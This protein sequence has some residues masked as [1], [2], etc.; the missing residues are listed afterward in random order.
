LA[1]IANEFAKLD[2]A[3]ELKPD[4]FVLHGDPERRL[5]P[6]KQPLESYGDHRIAMALSVLN[7]VN[8]LRT[9]PVRSIDWPLRQ[10][11]C[12]AVSYP[13]FYEQLKQLVGKRPV[14]NN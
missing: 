8:N 3:L 6:P 14:L 1:A 13:N 2:I 7:V 9:L 12:V 5:T 10:R 11:E 4:G